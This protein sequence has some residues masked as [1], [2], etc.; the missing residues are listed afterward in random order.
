MNV[1]TLHGTKIASF[2]RTATMNRPRRG[3][4][5]RAKCLDGV[6]LTEFNSVDGTGADSQIGFL[7]SGDMTAAGNATSHLRSGL[8]TDPLHGSCERPPNPA[9]SCDQ[10]EYSSRLSRTA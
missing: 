7:P 5:R 1:R 4:D 9:M 3:S 10:T 2:G 6:R 8:S